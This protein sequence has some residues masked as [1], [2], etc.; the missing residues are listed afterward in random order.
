MSTFQAYDPNAAPANNGDDLD[1]PSDGNHN[2]CTLTDAGAFTSKAGKDFVKFE[3]TN[4]AGHKWTVLQG[5]KSEAQTA[6][7]WSEVSKLGINPVEVVSLEDLDAVLKQHIGSYYDL[8]VKTNGQFRNT[9]INGPTTGSNPVVQ[10]QTTAEQ[11]E[12]PKQGDL[13]E[14][15]EPIPFLWD[16]PVDGRG[17]TNYNLF[18]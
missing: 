7:T 2:G 10:Q 6:V 9:Y 4:T 18:A 12:A 13:D 15:G 3:W 17:E 5:F 14:A 11:D 1:P 8:G 16:G